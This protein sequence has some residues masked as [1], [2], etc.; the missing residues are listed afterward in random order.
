MNFSQSNQENITNLKWFLLSV[1]LRIHKKY[2]QFIR[3]LPV[4]FDIFRIS[5][6]LLY[7]IDRFNLT[8]VVVKPVIRYSKKDQLK[9]YFR[10]E[11]KISKY[12]N[13]AKSGGP[14]EFLPLLV[15]RPAK[16]WRQFCKNLSNNKNRK[17]ERTWLNSESF[18]KFVVK[19]SKDLERNSGI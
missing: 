18:K 3:I 16:T 13:L 5:T 11:V 1:T 17:T 12:E 7:F 9:T 6:I 4:V 2:L 19:K 15:A 8:F 10:F 14:T